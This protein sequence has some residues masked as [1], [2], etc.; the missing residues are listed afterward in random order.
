VY[1]IH[2]IDASWIALLGIFAS[3]CLLL[4]YQHTKDLRELTTLIPVL[5]AT[6]I[7]LFEDLFGIDML[8]R[9]ALLRW[10]FLS[11]FGVKIIHFFADVYYDKF[12]KK[13]KRG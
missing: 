13:L 1:H 11:W 5:Y 2:M 12:M 4:R 3:V 7:Y 9:Q 10:A 8:L 6:G